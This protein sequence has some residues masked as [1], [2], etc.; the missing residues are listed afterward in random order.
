MIP[1]LLAICIILSM[2][3]SCGRAYNTGSNCGASTK[4]IYKA[5]Q[6]R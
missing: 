3:L 5:T 6:I 4:Q 1:Y 2:L